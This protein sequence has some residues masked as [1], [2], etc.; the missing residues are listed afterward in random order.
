[1]REGKIGNLDLSALFEFQRMRSSEAK[2]LCERYGYGFVIAEAANLW[3]QKPP[4]KPEHMALWLRALADRI[5]SE[6]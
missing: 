3:A 6:L 1:M 4:M 2:I 5:E